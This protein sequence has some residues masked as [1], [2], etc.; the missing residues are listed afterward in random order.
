MLSNIVQERYRL[1]NLLLIHLN[2]N[3]NLF[4]NF[5][6]NIRLINTENL[7]ILSLL[8]Q[9][10]VQYSSIDCSQVHRMCIEQCTISTYI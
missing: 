8:F 9:Y 3:S 4:C 5:C 1:I 7:Y 10:I 2:F 6:T